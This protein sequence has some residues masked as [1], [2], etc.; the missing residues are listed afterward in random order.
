MPTYGLMLDKEEL[1]A[2]D[3]ALYRTVLQG[4]NGPAL[5][6][7]YRA[8]RIEVRRLIHSAREDERILKP[9]E[10]ISGGGPGICGDVRKSKKKGIPNA[11]CVRPKGHSGLHKN[12][13]TG[14]WK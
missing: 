1:E 10:F 5:D 14:Y 4:G 8:M 3:R 11:V 12:K 7:K 13:Y 2:L 6:R 9:L